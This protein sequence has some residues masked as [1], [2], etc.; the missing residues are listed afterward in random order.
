MT[1]DDALTE[2]QPEPRPIVLIATVES[3]NDLEDTVLKITYSTT[4]SNS[5]LVIYV[6]RQ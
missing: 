5:D 4:R 2:R 3:I 6:I 1:F